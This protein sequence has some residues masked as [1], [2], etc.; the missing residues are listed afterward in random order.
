MAV[1]GNLL[2]LFPVEADKQPMT[3]PEY[4]KTGVLSHQAIRAMIAA[5][6]VGALAGISAD[7]I[8]PA[9]LDLRLGRRAYRV[10]ASFLP[11]PDATVMDRVRDLDGFPAIDLTSGGAVLEKGAVYV[12]E[13]Q[14]SVKLPAGLVGLD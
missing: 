1:E 13:L 5:G 7:Q 4:S 3:P 6:E 8:Q 10:R 14:E 2:R 11:G 9:S 12:V